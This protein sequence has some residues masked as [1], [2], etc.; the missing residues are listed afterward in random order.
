MNLKVDM[1]VVLQYK[2]FPLDFQNSYF[3][4]FR[5]EPTQ[6]TER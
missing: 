1:E 2:L 3:S 5:A 4:G 6:Q